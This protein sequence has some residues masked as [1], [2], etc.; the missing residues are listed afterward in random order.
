MTESLFTDAELDPEIAVQE[1]R[2]ANQRR[3]LAAWATHFAAEAIC[4]ACG[5]DAG[6]WFLLRIN[7]GL[8]RDIVPGSAAVSRLRKCV[9]MGWRAGDITDA[10][11]AAVRALEA[12]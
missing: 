9:V 12:S 10:D 4:P 5:Q 7:H 8:N 11:E 2:R 6:S 1:A 3:I